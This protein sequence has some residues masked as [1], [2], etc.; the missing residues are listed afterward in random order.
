MDSQTK[1][2]SEDFVADKQSPTRHSLEDSEAQSEISVDYAG[3]SRKTDPAEIALVRKLDT[4]MMPFLWIL[5]FMNIFNRQ[6]ISVARL[7]SLEEDLGINDTQFSTAVSVHYASYILGQIPSNLLLTRVR[8]AWYICGAMAMTSIATMLNVFVVNNTGLILQRFFLGIISAPYYP[9]AMYM[10][11]LFY[12]RKEIATRISI[13]FSANILATAFQ[14]LIAAP[15][16]SELGGVRGLSGWRWMYL[17]MGSF[18]LFFSITGLFFFP[19]KPT[20][21][22]WL[23]PA[24]KQLAA[25]R[26]AADTVERKEDVNLLKGLRECLKDRRVWVF[27]V[28]QHLQTA[29][30]SFRIFLPTLIDTLGFLR[31]VTLVL[32]CPPYI[33][34]GISSI[35]AGLSSGRFNERTW[36]ITIIKF[37]SIIGFVLACATMNTGARYFAAFVFVAATYPVSP[38]NLSWVGITCG[39]TSEKRAASLAA[40]NTLSSVSLIWTP[41]LWPDSAA[42]RYVLPMAASAGMC[43]ATVALSWY[44]RWDLMRENKRIRR[45]DNA[46]KIF[47]AY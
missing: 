26:I 36:H 8:P 43:F 35:L 14:G 2:I 1:S 44:M 38:L 27:M 17:I 41:Y 7:D 46:A 13:L 23:T 10:V 34:A 29:T 25:D 12:K 21:T 9:G 5:C 6:A 22:W 47:Y 4:C 20:T 37:V 24:Q 16:Y 39:Q 18:S 19:N 31:T 3:A 33:L 15:I 45:D 32:T 11:S 28:S 30:S 42:P 40:V